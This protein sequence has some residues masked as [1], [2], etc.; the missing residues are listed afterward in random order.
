M[1][2]FELLA[3]KTALSLAALPIVF[4]YYSEL[5][6]QDINPAVVDTPLV[7][8][9]FSG[10]LRRDIQNPG[11]LF[12]WNTGGEVAGLDDALVTDRPDFTEASSVVGRGVI[13]LETGYTYSHDKQDPRLSQEH[14]IGEPLL[15]FGVFR[16]WFEFR[17]GWN[18]S[19]KDISGGTASGGE[20][21][22]LGCKLGLTPQ[23]GFL[24]E[25]AVVPQMTLPTGSRAFT[26]STTLPG[27]NLL[28]GWD[29]SDFLA[30]GGSTQFNR[31]NDGETGH[32]YTEWAQSWT[33]GYSL[34]ERVGAYT[35]WFALFPNNADSDRV[36]H[37]FNGGFTLLINDDVQWDIRSG[38]G[39]SNAANDFFVGTG[40][41]F[42]VR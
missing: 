35:E 33:I 42:R 14:S 8:S 16:D 13:Q 22:Y 10:R 3:K 1:K 9:Y 23:A 18:F 38:V 25:V 41:S 31:T 21:L 29:L 27:C 28:Y 2:M 6:A 39:L 34:S 20:D 30:T 11:T 36:Q 26:S 24:P 7:P 12:T 17:L 32:V 5:G 4:G 40:L 15:R 19:A 37:Y